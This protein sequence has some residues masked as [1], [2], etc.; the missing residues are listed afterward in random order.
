[1]I[2]QIEKK[3]DRQGLKKYVALIFQ[4]EGKQFK[5]LSFMMEFST[6]CMDA[7]GIC[8]KFTAILTPLCPPFFLFVCFCPGVFCTHFYHFLNELYSV[9]RGWKA[10]AMT[11]RN[12]KESTWDNLI[13]AY[14]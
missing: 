13:A 14:V 7:P 12:I 3:K 8:Y 1:M 2:F 5:V 6:R 11:C 10:L 9:Q 4:A